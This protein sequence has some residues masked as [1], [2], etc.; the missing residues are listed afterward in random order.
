MP[1][2]KFLA[3][4]NVVSDSLRGE[5]AVLDWLSDHPAE[6]AISTLTPAE[7]RR[8][9]ELKSGNAAGHSCSHQTMRNRQAKLISE[10]KQL[11]ICATQGRSQERPRAG[12]A[13]FR[14]LPVCPPDDSDIESVV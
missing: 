5:K 4:T 9:I 6:V 12:T 7:I 10:V 14:S 3:D 1:L 8:G 11:C 2:L 13:C